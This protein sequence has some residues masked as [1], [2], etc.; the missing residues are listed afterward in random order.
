MAGLYEVIYSLFGSFRLALRDPDALRYFNLSPAGFW[1]SFTALLLS[2]P[3]LA[4][5]FYLDFRLIGAEIPALPFILSKLGI[6]YVSWLLYLV[7][8]GV[9]D[10]YIFETKKFGNFTIIYNWAQLALICVWLPFS[11][12][13][14][15]YLG[16]ALTSLL[17]LTFLIL[18]YVFLWYI[19]RRTLEI[20]GTAAVLMAFIEFVVALSL[21]QIVL[22]IFYG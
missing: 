6:T 7:I 3:L 18:S 21:H 19:L 12:L 16:L 17:S 14:M 11:I 22:R 5:D 13:S 15:G 9:A 4:L 1:A 10:Q 8:V 2:V 20:S